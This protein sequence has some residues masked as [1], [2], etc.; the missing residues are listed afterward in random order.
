MRVS[1]AGV[2]KKFGRT[3]AL[4]EVTIDFDPGQITAIIGLN[5]AGKTTLL[6]T[7]AGI[8]VPTEGEV[9]FDARVF[10]RDQLDVRRRMMF[11]PDYPVMFPDDSLIDHVASLFRIYERQTEN[12]EARV[13]ELMKDF[14][15]LPVADVPVP[16]LSRGQYYKC[17]LVGLIAIEP[18]LWL[19]DEPFASGMDPHG[20]A[21]F[22]RHAR[23][24]ADRGATII[25]TTQILEVAQ[26][27]CDRLVI[28]NAG[29]LARVMSGDEVRAAAATTA[30][31]DMLES[32]REGAQ[33]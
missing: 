27:L 16:T 11:I 13:I 20:L 21:A 18:D 10:S 14:D 23:A 32:F 30:L 12:A 26:R 24:A 17:G 2:T 7:I 15:V 31:D 19:L 33:A 5:G 3:S 8:V 25:Y 9:R 6:S 4:S 22:R 29:K 28:L 1:L